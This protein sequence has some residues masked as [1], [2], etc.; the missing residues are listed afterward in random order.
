[1]LYCIENGERQRVFSPFLF[2]FRSSL[3]RCPVNKLGGAALNRDRRRAAGPGRGRE[4][5]SCCRTKRISIQ[6][7][8]R[9]RT[10]VYTAARTIMI[11]YLRAARI[12]FLIRRRRRPALVSCSRRRMLISACIHNAYTYTVFIA[13]YVL[14]I[15]GAVSRR[16]R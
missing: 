2:L 16:V 3:V 12:M 1:M 11:Y 13:M 8:T 7:I 5:L 9:A 14:C 4:E 6:N 15:D 10:R